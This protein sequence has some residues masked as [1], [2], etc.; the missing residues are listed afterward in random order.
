MTTTTEAVTGTVTETASE[1]S[2]AAAHAAEGG[3]GLPQLNPEHFT[4]QLVW[5]VL[6]FVVL[7]LLMS[8]LLVPL[9]GGVLEA[10]SKRIQGDLDEAER[11]KAE[12]QKAIA[13]YEKAL[14]DARNKAHGMAQE[15]RDKLKAD[16]DAER[17]RI[18]KEQAERAAAAE[19]AIEKAKASALSQVDAIA[20]D[21]AAAVIER[22]V[23]LKP[24]PDELAAAVGSVR[25]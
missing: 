11:L 3:G 13:D 10:R 23:G 7:Y 4:P 5:L 20:S 2:G 22:L 18:E 8:R 19:A 24:S 9:I 17:A 6:T 25:R 12:T 16:V 21:T 14:A 15:T 1:V